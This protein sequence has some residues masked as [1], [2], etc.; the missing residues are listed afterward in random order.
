[1]KY[2]LLILGYDPISIDRSFSSVSLITF[3]IRKALEKLNHIEVLSLPFIPSKMEY[4][5]TDFVLL[6]CYA[7]IT[8]EQVSEIKEKTKA[9]KIITLREINFIGVGVDYS[10]VFNSECLIKN[11]TSF[12]PLP[13]SKDLLI[14][15]P[16]E[17][18]TILIDH[19]WENYLGTKNEWTYDI[20]NWTEELKEDYKIYR[21][22]RS[23][24]KLNDKIKDYEIPLETANYP[25]Y[26]EQTSTIEN[27]I[28]THHEGYPYGVIDMAARGTRV[29]TPPGFI[30]SSIVQPLEIPIFNNKQELLDIVTTPIETTWNSK[31]D[32]CTDYDTIANIIDS[33]I[34]EWIT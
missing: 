14:P 6:I 15:S 3:C 25:T 1:M 27:F 32:Q 10:F 8:T 34:Q 12:I 17:P 9:K 11:I 2:K 26:L 5:I 21:I 7:G 16:K 18:K 22:I 31:I 23:Q 19:C 33:K 29:L 13:C 4:P 30:C 28:V 24:D 20:E